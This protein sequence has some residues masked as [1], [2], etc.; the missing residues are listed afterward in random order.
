MYFDFQSFDRSSLHTLMSQWDHQ[1]NG[2]KWAV[3]RSLQGAGADI[4]G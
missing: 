4:I 3:W 1:L 2:S